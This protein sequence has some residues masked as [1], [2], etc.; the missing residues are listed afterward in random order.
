MVNVISGLCAVDV[1]TPFTL[2]DQEVGTSLDRS[3]I[4]TE[5]LEQ[6]VFELVEKLAVGMVCAIDSEAR[7]KPEH[8]SKLVSNLFFIG[9]FF[10]LF[11]GTRLKG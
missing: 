5:D 9:R 10:V 4:C 3:V 11:I 2:Y 6:I 8:I 1:G 7:K